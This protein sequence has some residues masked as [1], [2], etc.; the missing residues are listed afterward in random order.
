MA[1]SD[2][3]T[4]RLLAACLAQALSVSALLAATASGGA[5][6]AGSGNGWTECGERAASGRRGYKT[7]RRMGRW[8][9]WAAGAGGAWAV[10]RRHGSQRRGAGDVDVRNGDG[11]VIASHR[12]GLGTVV[13]ISEWAR[14]QLLSGRLIDMSFIQ[15]YNIELSISLK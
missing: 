15:I 4:R 12:M 13:L 9:G 1:S 7:R 3:L 10:L 2:S 14:T 8:A 11:S 5:T 6:L